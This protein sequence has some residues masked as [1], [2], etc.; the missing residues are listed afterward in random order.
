MPD[1]N[2]LKTRVSTKGQVILPK[3]LRE[4]HGWGAGTVLEV[5]DGPHGVTLRPVP[6]VTP[7]R[8]VPRVIHNAG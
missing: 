6:L 7:T 1:G 4:R 8:L 5:V 3:A 2:R